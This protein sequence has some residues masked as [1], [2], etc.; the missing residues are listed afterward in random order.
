MNALA[1]LVAESHSIKTNA[2]GGIERDAFSYG[3][4]SPFITR[5]SRF[6][7]DP[8]FTKVV[9][10]SGG[11]P[12][13]GGTLNWSRE[14]AQLCARIFGDET[15]AWKVHILNLRSVAYDLMPMVLGSLLELFAFE[16]FR[17]GQGGSHPTLLVLEEV[18]AERQLEG[19]TR[20]W[21]ALDLYNR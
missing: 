2:R 10:E 14:G 1:C 8:M 6:L 3:N 5:I 9:N 21:N 7:E 4:V 16:L 15:T 17:R 13:A 19:E 11:H 18:R 20:H 12:L